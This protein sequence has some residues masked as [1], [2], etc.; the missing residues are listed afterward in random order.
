MRAWQLLRDVLLTGT[1]VFIL[2]SQVFSK[3]PSDVLLAAALALTA[4]SAADHV[5]ALLSRPGESESSSSR[6]SPPEDPS[7]P[8]SGAS[9]D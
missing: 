7:A 5:K 6:S 1:A 9:G 3:D 4:P 8:S 2:I